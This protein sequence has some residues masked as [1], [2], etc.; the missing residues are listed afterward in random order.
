V[1]DASEVIVIGNGSPEFPAAVQRCRTDQVVIDLVR[2]P[3]DFS[4]VRAQYDGICW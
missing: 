2:I 1:I 3:L 4:Q